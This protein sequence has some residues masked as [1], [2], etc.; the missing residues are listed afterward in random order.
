MYHTGFENKD[1]IISLRPDPN[2][3]VLT[4]GT[5]IHVVMT[6]HSKCSFDHLILWYGRYV[7]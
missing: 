3:F 1:Q 7:F 6:S 2:N 5:P 4:K